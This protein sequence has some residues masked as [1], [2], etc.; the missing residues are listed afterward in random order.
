LSQ[1]I[2]SFYIEFSSWE[3]MK[4]FTIQYTLNAEELP[5]D[6]TGSLSVEIQ[7]EIIDSP[8]KRPKQKKRRS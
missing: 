4:S 1:I 8:L 7:K 2:E 3:E 6:V 5:S